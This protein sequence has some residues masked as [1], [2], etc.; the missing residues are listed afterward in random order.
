MTWTS[1]PFLSLAV[2]SIV[3]AAVFIGS[4]RL[5]GFLRQREVL[6]HPN[7]RS[8]HLAPTPRGGGIVVIGVILPVWAG[9]GW[10]APQIFTHPSTVSLSSLV[11]VLLCALGLAVMSWLDDLRGLTPIFRLILQFAVVIVGLYTL[12]PG[13]SGEALVFQ[14]LLPATA[15]HVVAAL[16]WVWFLNLFNFMDGIDGITG[17][18]AASVGGGVFLVA[19]FAGG[20][21]DWAF[22]GLS[23]AAAAC[24]FLCWNWD[25]AKLF[26][27]D[28]GSVP[29]GFLLGWLL[30]GL[31]TT[32]HWAPAVIL[33][34]YYLADATLTLG[35]RLLRGEKVWQAHSQHFYQR[36]VQ[37][38]ASHAKVCR[39]VGVA[40]LGLLLLAVVTILELSPNVPLLCIAAAALVVA[41]LMA[42]L[43]NPGAG[44]NCGGRAPR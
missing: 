41:G 14:G 38:G 31:T 4:G 21:Q 12:P 37:A 44:Q 24:G 3:F 39:L 36:A 32:G 30:L 23:A 5:V 17:V 28:V 8:S 33:P 2:F 9:V 26:I 27:G 29:L 22:F 43:K 34:L 19:L 16:V 6:D 42:R 13:P 10:F 40:N 25:P 18:E 7:K 15:D 35:L 1:V 11:L 20:I